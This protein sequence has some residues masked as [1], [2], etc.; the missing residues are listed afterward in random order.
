MTVQNPLT[1]KDFQQLVYDGL[2]MN[3]YIKTRQLR[4]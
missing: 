3:G 4:V 2:E 1:E